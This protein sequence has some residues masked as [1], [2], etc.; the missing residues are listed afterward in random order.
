MEFRIEFPWQLNTDVAGKA[1]R[2]RLLTRRDNSLGAFHQTRVGRPRLR[3]HGP[4]LPLMVLAAIIG[5]RSLTIELRSILERDEP[6]RHRDD[7]GYCHC[8][9][10]V[11]QIALKPGISPRKRRLAMNPRS[12]RTAVDTFCPPHLLNDYHL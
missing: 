11:R 10:P 6:V 5:G 12:F 9:R 2:R 8:L 1:V 4:R 7:R 3:P